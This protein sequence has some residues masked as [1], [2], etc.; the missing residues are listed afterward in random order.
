MPHSPVGSG[1]SRPHAPGP[2]GPTQRGMWGPASL[3]PLPVGSGVCGRFLPTPGAAVP[4]RLRL[5]PSPPPGRAPRPR[6]RVSGFAVAGPLGCPP[7]PSLGPCA[8]FPAPW[9]LA[10]APVLWLP[11]AALWASCGR[12][13][14]ARGRPC[15]SGRLAGSPRPRPLGA[16]GLRPL[17]AARPRGLRARGLPRPG[18]GGPLG[19]LSPPCPGLFFVLG[20]VAPCAVPFSGGALFRWGSPP[21]PPARRPP[22]GGSGSARPVWVGLRPPAFGGSPRGV[23]QAV[24]F[25][26]VAAAGKGQAGQQCCPCP[27]R[28]AFFGARP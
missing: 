6:Y 13:C 24:R 15:A 10:A 8:P 27:C 9:P 28:C 23:R 14:C 11:L 17:A 3:A 5:L 22:L 26:I 20:C 21:A 18:R 2:N 25:P 19:R 1:A 16:S 4:L 7:A 12:P